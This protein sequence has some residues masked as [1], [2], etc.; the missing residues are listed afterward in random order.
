MLLW[1]DEYTSLHIMQ[2]KLHLLLYAI[3]KKEGKPF[4]LILKVLYESAWQ[5]D[6]L[7]VN[8]SKQKLQ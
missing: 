5:F 2:D 4:E 3:F 6:T 8:C 1:E 7:F